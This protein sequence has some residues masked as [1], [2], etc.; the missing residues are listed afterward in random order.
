MSLPAQKLA[1]ALEK[2]QAAQIDGIV[3]S[4]RLMRTT[5]TRLIEAGFLKEIIRGWHF[6]SNPALSVGATAWYCHYWSFIRQYL[7]ARFGE[8]YCLLPEISLSLH[9][10]SSVVPKQL[11]VMRRS[12]GQ[13]ILPL[14]L[15]TSLYI[16]QERGAFP[17]R[18]AEIN[19]VRAIDLNEALARVPERF[20]RDNS[21]DAL[22]ALRMSRDPTKLISDLLENGRSVVA[23]RLSGAFR[24]IGD[25]AN[26][27]RILQTMKSAGYDVREVNPFV[28]PLFVPALQSRSESPY[29]ARL[30]GMWAEMRLDVAEMFSISPPLEVEPEA[31]LM[32]LEEKY[33][34]D[35]YHSLSIEGYQVTPDLIEKVRGG[36]WNPGVGLADRS[37]QDALAAR[38]YFE[39]FQAVKASVGEIL[40]GAEA[41]EI[42]RRAHHEWHRSLFAPSVQA[43]LLKPEALAGYRQSPVFIHGSRHVPLPT[44]SLMDSVDTLFEL[45]AQE[46]HPAVRSVLGHFMFV[47]IHPYSDGNGRIGRFLMNALLA[48]GGYPWTI[49][50][51]ENRLKYMEALEEASVNRNIKPFAGCILAEMQAPN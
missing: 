26:A 16:Y 7:E 29:V 37:T 43:G 12:P 13:Q 23:G 21:D 2:M 17:E 9:T 36:I 4:E 50:H 28:K 32:Q 27:D 15:N 34:Q 38:G 39:A 44:H 33:V 1:D 49:I 30:Q 47:F 48:S 25:S 46:T 19:G 3:R 41:V 5:L 6:V 10:G 14:C 51:V 18:T 42:V 20:F 35:A 24:H 11:S 31:Y 22:I 45:L 8:D 40:Q